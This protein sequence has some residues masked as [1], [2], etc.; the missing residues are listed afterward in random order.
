MGVVNEQMRQDWTDKA[1]EWVA[2]EAIFDAVF[3]PATAAIFDAALAEPGCRLLDVGCGSGALLAA[4]VAAGMTG[5]G[6]DISPGMAEAARRRV[7]DATVIVGD[8]QTTDL[9]A[10][11]PGAPFDRVVSRFG[12]MFFA[13]PTA[14]FANIRRA[15]AP[16]ALMSFACWRATDENPL[17][18]LGH[19]VLAE[20]LASRPGLPPGAPGPTAF[21]DPD[22]VVSL[23]AGAGWSSITVNAFDFECDYGIDGSDGVEERLA[24]IL[25]G[26]T[27]RLAREELEPSLGPAGW[28]ALLDDVRAELRRHLVDGAVR[29]PGAIWLV[30][31]ANVSR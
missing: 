4:G 23:L 6:V 27:G 11:A 24:T 12:V 1:A 9:L 26:T 16:K 8:A 7:P 31:A 17:F 19:S 14:A 3:A 21:A 13:D 18:T 28:A 29:F 22:R 20:R 25:A 10:E 15:A 5:V 30:T 2:N